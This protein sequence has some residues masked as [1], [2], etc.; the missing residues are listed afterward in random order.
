MSS[1][2]ILL[3]CFQACLIQ[4]AFSCSCLRANP[5]AGQISAVNNAAAYNAASNIAA[6]NIAASNFAAA[7]NAALINAA[8]YENSVLGYGIGAGYSAY[9]SG[10]VAVSGELGVSGSTSIAGSVPVTGGLTFCGPVPASGLVTISGGCS[11][12]QSYAAAAAGAELAVINAGLS[13]YPQPA[14]YG[15]GLAQAAGL[16]QWNGFVAPSNGC[17]IPGVYY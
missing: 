2:A 13:A 16:N 12:P 1:F 7:N 4:T 5:V 6:S 14:L 10:D 8:A 15:A 17:G 9:G 11:C 3:L